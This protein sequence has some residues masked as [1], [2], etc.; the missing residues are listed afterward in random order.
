MC[1]RERERINKLETKS[2]RRRWKRKYI[3]QRRREEIRDL[4]EKKIKK[5]KEKLKREEK[6]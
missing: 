4:G 1:D 5:E 2:V 6:C 3:W